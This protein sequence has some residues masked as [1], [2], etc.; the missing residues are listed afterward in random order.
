MVLCDEKPEDLK[1]FLRS[2]KNGTA[3]LQSDMKRIQQ[4]GDDSGPSDESKEHS[5]TR[6]N[7]DVDEEPESID[8]DEL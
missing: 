5:E 8:F 1:S 2:L 4:P 7:L 6:D 3:K